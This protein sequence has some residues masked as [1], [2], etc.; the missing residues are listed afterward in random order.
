[1]ET[2]S[3]M[4]TLVN[5]LFVSAILISF[6]ACSDQDILNEL[7]TENSIELRPDGMVESTD[8]VEIVPGTGATLKPDGWQDGRSKKIDTPRDSDPSRPDG[9]GRSDIAK[10]DTDNDAMLRSNGDTHP[11]KDNKTRQTPSKQ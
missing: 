5:F 4:K 6:T 8:I 1:M 10:V 7:Q 11:G 2:K 3:T 9:S